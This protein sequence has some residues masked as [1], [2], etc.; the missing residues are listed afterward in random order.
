[1]KVGA[2]ANVDDF[3][4]L[5]GLAVVTKISVRGKVDDLARGNGTSMKS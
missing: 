5:A 3:M 1:M 2:R 4:Y